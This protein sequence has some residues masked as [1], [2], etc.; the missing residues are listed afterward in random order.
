M[1]VG[2]VGAGAIG[3]Y[4]GGRL[5]A[6]GSDA[7]FFG[8]PRVRDALREH[9]LTLEDGAGSGPR[10]R[11]E[12]K[13]LAFVVD[14]AGLST[15]D[16]LL[17]CVK[18]GQS[19][20][21]ARDLAAVVPRGALVVS[22]QNGLRNAEVLRAALPHQVVL[23]GIVGFNVV[24]VRPGTF[25][26]ATTAP[27]VI[28]AQADARLDELV[29]TLRG[30]NLETEV[31][32]DLRAKQWSKLVMNLNNALSAL[33]GVPTQRL[34]F[35]ECYRRSVR[36]VTEEALDVIARAGQKPSRIGPLPVQVFPYFLR[37]PSAVLRVVTRIQ[38]KIDPT[39][40]SS[41]WDDLTR[42]RVTEVDYLNG[43]IVR[44]AASIGAK[45]PINE[46]VVAL[47]RDAERRA[48]GPPNLS[49]DALWSALHG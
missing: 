48:E 16:V 30:A 1:K 9:G 13:D 18:S 33:T 26:R 41:M 38:A 37:L 22:M 35:E 42:R 34:I 19:D 6:R 11:V 24:E 43:E 5:R 46:K 15:C 23:G 40:R 21:V 10:L 2:I 31:V 32:H 25:R 29:D 14:V 17:V 45:A 20:G 39:A 12:P 27:L 7:V 8:R 3:C 49:A 4:V 28:E 36:A 44:L 47:I